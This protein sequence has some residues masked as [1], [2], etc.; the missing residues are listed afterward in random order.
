MI[1]TFIRSFEAATDVE[2]YTIATFAS[3]ATD[4]TVGEAASN[5]N[6]L[7]GVFD[8]LGGTAG[9]MVDV[10]FAGMVEVKLGGAVEA[11][12]AITSDASGHGVLAAAGAGVHIIGFA[13]EPGASGDIID[14]WM[15][16][17]R[18]L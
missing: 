2:G 7:I 9:Q 6:A 1:P 14:V 17:S 18:Q 12:Q 3:P 8:K 15:A 16:Q 10:H 13:A 11:G 4:N 5:T